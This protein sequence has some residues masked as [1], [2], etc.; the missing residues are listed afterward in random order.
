MADR[1]EKQ[2]DAPYW[3]RLVF[4][5]HQICIT[6]LI[7]KRPGKQRD[8]KEVVAC[9]KQ[10]HLVPAVQSLRG[11]SQM[12]PLCIHPS[13]TVI[14]LPHKYRFRISTPRVLFRDLHSCVSS[15]KMTDIT[16]RRTLNITC[17]I[18]ILFNL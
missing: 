3:G 5:Q 12:L 15:S 14:T 6:K 2:A 18:V 7:W 1:T 4:T 13:D 8:K 17:V 16:R 11:P 10:S 9:H